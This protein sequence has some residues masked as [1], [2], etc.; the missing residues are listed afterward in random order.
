MDD[1]IS[2]ML[3]PV[4]AL[5]IWTLVLQLRKNAIRPRAMKPNGTRPMGRLDAQPSNVSG[6]AE[7]HTGW[8]AHNH[9]LVEQPTLFY[10]IAIS[11]A[12][13][14]G[15]GPSVTNLVLAWTYVFFRIAH[16]V[17]E[18]TSNGILYKLV[19]F[20]LA[21]IALLGLALHAAIHAW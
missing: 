17:V 19:L 15:H 11:M 12:L 7:D 4:V 9:D 10:A 14:H 3:A 5:I 13:L 21:S 18:V 1:E 16:S 6:V 20:N 8:N 2:P